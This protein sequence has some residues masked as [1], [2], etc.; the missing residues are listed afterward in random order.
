MHC[1]TKLIFA[2]C[3]VMATL[4]SACAADST[5]PDGEELDFV[6]IGATQYPVQDVQT[7]SFAGNA[8]DFYVATVVYAE[9]SALTLSF[10]VGN[11]PG[12]AA[13]PL[14]AQDNQLPANGQSQSIGDVT[15]DLAEAG[16]ASQSLFGGVQG[17]LLVSGGPTHPVFRDV[18][19]TFPAAE[20]SREGHTESYPRIDVTLSKLSFPSLP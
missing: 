9:D 15:G 14:N 20:F 11:G 2:A 12:A 19:L 7:D 1:A 8:H 6:Q 16:A 10:A 3:L 4:A 5:P 13:L 17:T 18:E